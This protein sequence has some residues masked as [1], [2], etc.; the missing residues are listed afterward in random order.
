MKK[1]YQAV[2]PA[3]GWND[4]L[5]F[6]PGVRVGGLL[7]ISGMTAADPS[8]RIVGED[9]IVRQTEYIFEKMAAVLAA[10]GLDFSHVVETTDYFTDLKDY[11]RTAQ[12]R[13]KVFG[14]PPY[15]AATGVRVAGLIRP[16]ALIEIKAVAMFPEEKP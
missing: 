8:G 15:P 7:F 9:D 11:A 3:S 12:V 16:T 4:K 6:S 5:T 13:R 2:F 10:A 14:G 1:P